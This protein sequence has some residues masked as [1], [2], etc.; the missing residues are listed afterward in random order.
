[1]A[2][3]VNDSFREFG[4]KVEDTFKEHA[5]RVEEEVQKVIAYLNDEVVPGVREGSTKALKSASEQLSKL[6]EYLDRKT[7]GK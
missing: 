4:R 7:G 3:Q 6:A 1:M 2:N 5:P